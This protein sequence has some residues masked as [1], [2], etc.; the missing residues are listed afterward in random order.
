MQL[1]AMCD[2][3][4]ALSPSERK[5][6]KHCLEILENGKPEALKKYQPSTESF[7]N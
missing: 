2:T 5:C 1:E 3:R 7:M 6:V 4:K